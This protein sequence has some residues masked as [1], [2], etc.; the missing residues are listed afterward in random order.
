MIMSNGTRDELHD[1]WAN[2]LTG[3]F[4][5]GLTMIRLTTDSMLAHR[6][7]ALRKNFSTDL[8]AEKLAD[9]MGGAFVLLP[10]GKGPRDTYLFIT[11]EAI[12]AAETF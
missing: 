2:D 6:P 9:R 5:G 3:F 7:G 4:M 11:R 12:E 8:V 1:D 10:N